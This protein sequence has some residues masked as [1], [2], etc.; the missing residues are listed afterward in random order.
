MSIGILTMTFVV[1]ARQLSA[2]IPAL[3]D[4][5]QPFVGIAWPWFVLIGTTITLTAGIL[6]SLTHPAPEREPRAEEGRP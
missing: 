2:A 5:L 1:F 4:T 6:S 3:A